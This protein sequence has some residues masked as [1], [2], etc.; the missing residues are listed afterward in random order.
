MEEKIKEFEGISFDED[1]HYGA[2]KKHL[3]QTNIKAVKESEIKKLNRTI[4]DLVD[5]GICQSCNRKLDNVDNSAHIE[6]H[7]KEI[8]KTT[9]E[10]NEVT[11]IITELEKLLNDLNETKT[12]I[13]QKNKLEL[14]KVILI[15]QE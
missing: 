11:K 4:K 13:D 5:G 10:L 8:E 1:L 2:T 9:S 15:R 12:K 6:K 14:D 3:E 7:N